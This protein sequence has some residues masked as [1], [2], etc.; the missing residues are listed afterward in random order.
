MDVLQRQVDEYENE[1]RALKDFKSPTGRRGAQGRAP[2]RALTSVND[3]SATNESIEE[4]LSTTLSLEATLFRPALQQALRETWKW[5]A[6][7]SSSALSNLSPLPGPFSTETKFDDDLSQLSA[8]LRDVRMKKASVKLVDLA[9]TKM[10]PS[11]QLQESRAAS[12]TAS[13]KLETLALRL[14]GRV[15]A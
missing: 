8:A 9:N 11:L 4:A 10:S 12:L 15:T 1:I 13:R 7:A 2:R 14:G 3:L 5:K 6:A